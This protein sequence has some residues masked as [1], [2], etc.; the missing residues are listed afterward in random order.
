MCIGMVSL[1]VT[2]LADHQYWQPKEYKIVTSI[3]FNPPYEMCVHDF[4]LTLINTNV[5]TSRFGVSDIYLTIASLLTES[6]AILLN[7]CNKLMIPWI[8]S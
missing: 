5:C 7:V 1:G 2:P 8:S 6:S 3:L 4:I